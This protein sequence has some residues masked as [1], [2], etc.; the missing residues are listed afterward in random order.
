MFKLEKHI[1]AP[2]KAKYPF[3]KMEI[4]DSFYVAD[5]DIKITAVRVAASDYAIKHPTFAFR[6]QRSVGNDGCRVW[7][8]K[9]ESA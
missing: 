9:P 8:I 5:C 7:R 2:P 6:V 4:G 1:P 3:S